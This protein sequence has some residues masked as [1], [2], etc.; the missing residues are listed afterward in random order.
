[1]TEK[2]FSNWISDLDFEFWS[3]GQHKVAPKVFLEKWAQDEAVLL[4]V[5]ADQEND[6]VT[7]PFALAIPIHEIPQRLD[8]IPRDKLVATFCSGGDRAG[9]AFAYLR[10][11]G[12]DN[13]RILKA[14]YADLM[15]ELLPGKLRQ[16]LQS[17]A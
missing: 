2:T 16:I 1:M 5:R 10:T 14:T 8:E 3:T 7:L 13:V 6:F 17:K 9:V 11:Q 12:F 15:A 4:D